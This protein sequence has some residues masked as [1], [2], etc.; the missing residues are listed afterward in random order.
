MLGTLLA[1]HRRRIATLVLALAAG[2]GFGLV[3][4]YAPWWVS[5]G[6]LVALYAVAFGRHLRRRGR[7]AAR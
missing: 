2:T 1:G 6:M 3:V 5:V 4:R 7:N